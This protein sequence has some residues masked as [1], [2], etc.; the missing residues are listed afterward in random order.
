M[1][2]GVTKLNVCC[3]GERFVLGGTFVG[4]TYQGSAIGDESN[5]VGMYDLSTG[6][7]RHIV[8]INP[9]G[10]GPDPEIE[11]FSY[12]VRMVVTRTGAMAWIVPAPLHDAN[13][14]V[15]DTDFVLTAVDGNPLT[16]RII[17]T[18]HIDPKSV[19][20]AADGHT[21]TWTRDGAPQTT[22][23]AP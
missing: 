20:L 19:K 15:S 9:N 5:K 16:E 14:G 23:L 6:K 4:Y 2:V 11:T 21:L 18:G 17:D 1:P 13:G 8:K 7:Q 10:E 3:E 12:V 22:A